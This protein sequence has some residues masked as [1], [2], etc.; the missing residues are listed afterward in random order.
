MRAKIRAPIKMAEPMTLTLDYP[1]SKY[2]L[3]L[4]LIAN[5]HAVLKNP[6][7]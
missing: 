5:I 4:H 3:N 7:S 6:Y 2:F 1:A